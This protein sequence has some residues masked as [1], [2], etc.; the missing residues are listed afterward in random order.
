MHGFS[1]VY[2]LQDAC[3]QAVLAMRHGWF[4][5]DIVDLAALDCP[6]V[7]VRYPRELFWQKDFC[8]D[9]SHHVR[10]VQQPKQAPAQRWR[11]FVQFVMRALNRASEP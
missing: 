1:E 7:R 11:G 8:E 2:G 5:S 4:L 9:G 3:G 10:G 6:A